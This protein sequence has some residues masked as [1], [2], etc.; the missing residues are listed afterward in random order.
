M[1]KIGKSIFL[2][3]LIIA[4]AGCGFGDNSV[5]DSC[6]NGNGNCVACSDGDNNDYVCQPVATRISAVRAHEMMGQLDEFMLLDVRT[7]VEFQTRRI[8]GAVLIPYDEILNRAV[9]EIIRKDIVILVYCQSGRRSAIAAQRLV[10]LGFCRVYDFGGIAAW[11][12]E[13]I[14]GV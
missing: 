3:M 8:F 1:K 13:T 10:E 12:F 7:A 9:T 5:D 6:I 2:I 14:G 11:P 4:L